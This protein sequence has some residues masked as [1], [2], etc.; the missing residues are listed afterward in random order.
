MPVRAFVKKRRGEERSDGRAKI[1]K[2]ERTEVRKCK[3]K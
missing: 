2:R 1:E 3:K